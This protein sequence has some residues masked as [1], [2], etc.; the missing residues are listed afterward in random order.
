MA[1]VA[2]VTTNAASGSANFANVVGLPF[3]FSYLTKAGFWFHR[4]IFVVSSDFYSV[5]KSHINE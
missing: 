2:I 4:T 3:V 1:F 5:Q